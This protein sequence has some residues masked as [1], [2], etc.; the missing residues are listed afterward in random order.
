MKFGKRI[1]TLA[2]GMAALGVAGF[3]SSSAMAASTNGTAN[4]TLV[5]A[6]SIAAVQ[7]L[8]FGSI[9]N[10][11]N[12]VTIDT[13]GTRTATDATQLAGG[14]PQ[15]A[16]FTVTGNGAAAFTVTLPASTTITN[17]TDNL[18]VNNFTHNAPAT[19]TAGT[20]NFDVGADLVIVGGESAGAYTGTFT[21]TVNY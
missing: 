19:L 7:S 12:T 10:A 2:V 9:G 18:T 4:A 15:A 13:A 20:A 17:G 8:E 16:R 14:A 21:V 3:A 11:A 1:S 5:T 6:I